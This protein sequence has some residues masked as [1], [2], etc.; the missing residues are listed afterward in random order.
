MKKVATLV[1][2][3]ELKVEQDKMIKLQA[4]DSSYF[5]GKSHFVGNAERI[6]FQNEN[7]RNYLMKLLNLLLHLMIILLQH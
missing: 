7:L 4:F 3:A 6:I 2:K 1:T 5:P